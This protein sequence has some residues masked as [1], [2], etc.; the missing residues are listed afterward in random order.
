MKLQ[1]FISFLLTLLSFASS[2]SL[3]EQYPDYAKR[4]Y[5]YRR[6][7]VTG[8]GTTPT[9]GT[10]GGGQGTGGGTVPIIIVG[11]GGASNAT[12]GQAVSNITG[13]LNSTQLQEI[14]TQVNQSLSSSSNGVVIV[15]SK[16]SLES[17]AFY[18]AI[19]TNT[20]KA[21]VVC[22]DAQLGQ[23]VAKSP[24]A[25]G[26]GPLIVGK[27]KVIFSGTLPPWGVPVGVIGDNKEAYW[28]TDACHPLLTSPNSTLRTEFSNFTSS[29]SSNNS[30][31]VVPIVYEEGL[32]SSLLNSLSS[33]I[34]GLVVISS[35][36][37]STST[38]SESVSIPIVYTNPKGRQI[39]Y[40]SN[41][42]IPSNAIAG[43]YLSPIQAQI[44]LS[45]AV[46]KGVHNTESLK[47]IFPS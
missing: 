9:N 17:I 31:V 34:Q 14:G 10:S 22:D 32:E 2:I 20:E 35:G 46:S 18:L 7:N 33:S 16:A 21:I 37:N 38:S 6:Q 47:S 40:I 28:F 4:S 36:S 45:I 30:N 26:R 5:L 15:G 27:K 44:L 13:V 42:T 3:P 23:V 29:S 43:G 1:V 12:G 19:T 11:A 8:N 25:G 41:S 24:H 39:S